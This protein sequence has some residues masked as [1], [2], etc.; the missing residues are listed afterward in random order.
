MSLFRNLTLSLLT[1]FVALSSSACTT[2]TQSPQVVCPEIAQYTQEQQ[3]GLADELEQFVQ[4]NAAPYSRLFL[5]H[6]RQLRARLEA[7]GCK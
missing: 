7:V 4:M 3:L 2:T 1:I 5:I 6:Y